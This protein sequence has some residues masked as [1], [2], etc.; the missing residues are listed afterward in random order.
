[1][2]C[3]S[4]QLAHWVMDQR[5]HGTL[6]SPCT[7]AGEDPH[8][9]I[10][11][12]VTSGNPALITCID[13]ERLEFQSGDLVVFSEVEGMTELNDG[14]PRKIKNCK[15]RQNGVEFGTQVSQH[16]CALAAD[17]GAPLTFEPCV[18]SPTTLSST[19]TPRAMGH[20]SEAGWSL[21]SSHPRL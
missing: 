19:V 3:V 20:T 2:N 17:I 7:V 1:M 15:V 21:S 6:H 18:C 5:M 13:D 14:K 10:I 16:L 4:P 9:G 11:A 12:S 8:S